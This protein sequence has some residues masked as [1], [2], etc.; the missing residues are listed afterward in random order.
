[1]IAIGNPPGLINGYSG[2][3]SG[4]ARTALA[5]QFSVFIQTDAA[6]NQTIPVAS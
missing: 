6:I 4:L 1:V 5:F 2:I 3:V